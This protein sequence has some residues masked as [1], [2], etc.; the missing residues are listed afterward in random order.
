MTW[1]LQNKSETKKQTR[2]KGTNPEFS[3]GALKLPLQ[4]QT[5]AAWSTN[6]CCEIDLL[7]PIFAVPCRRFRT[8][9]PSLPPKKTS[10]DSSRTRLHLRPP[11]PSRNRLSIVHLLPAQKAWRSLCVLTVCHLCV[12][13]NNSSILK[14][15]NSQ[16]SG[17]T[18]E[19]AE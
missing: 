7:H 14:I 4:G 18:S 11:Q 9:E 10:I 17:K 15:I 19:C 8:L 5:S 12:D 13:E 6:R 3:F 16:N 2:K 1:Q